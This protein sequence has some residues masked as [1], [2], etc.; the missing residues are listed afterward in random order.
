[1]QEISKL[2]NEAALRTPEWKKFLNKNKQRLMKMDRE[3]EQLHNEVSSEIDC[4]ECGNCCRSLGPMIL[5]K[6]I[7]TLAKQLKMKS[8]DFIKKFLQKDEDGDFVFQSMPC[9]FLG[10]DNYCSVYENRPKACREYP[11]TNRKKFYQIY[12]LTIKN[13]S[14][15]PIAF[16]VLN[17]LMKL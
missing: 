13:A 5:E 15:C 11:H 7:D 2:H 9:P 16:D 12:N 17:R 14:T 6:D 3:I 8:S 1:M 4:L 10:S